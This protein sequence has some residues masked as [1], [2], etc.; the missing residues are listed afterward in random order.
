MSNIINSDDTYINNLYYELFKIYGD[1][2]NFR[3]EAI[4]E[5]HLA[6]YLCSLSNDDLKNLDKYSLSIFNKYNGYNKSFA[7]EVFNKSISDINLTS[8]DIESLCASEYFHNFIRL[9]DDFYSIYGST[10]ENSELSYICS[11]NLHLLEFRRIYQVL[12]DSYNK[13][14]EELLCDLLLEDEA[15]SPRAILYRLIKYEKDYCKVAFALFLSN[16]IKDSFIKKPIVGEDNLYEINLG[17]SS[18]ICEYDCYR[19]SIFSY[20]PTT[21]IKMMGDIEVISSGKDIYETVQRIRTSA[22]N[23]LDSKKEQ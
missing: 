6:E 8:K 18:H 20:N 2:V 22:K 23:L 19:K 12:C 1:E 16:L 4:P 13:S 3:N 10:I 7:S 17:I 15:L 21:C 11:Q 14:D 5:Y 9:I